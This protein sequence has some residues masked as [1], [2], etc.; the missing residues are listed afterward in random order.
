LA[1]VAGL[2]IVSIRPWREPAEGLVK[3][4][5][6]VSIFFLDA[7]MVPIIFWVPDT[8]TGARSAML[9]TNDALIPMDDWCGSTK[10]AICNRLERK[11]RVRDEADRQV[12]LISSSKL[13]PSF[14]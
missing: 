4:H 7:S 14:A 11:A 1:A 5:T 9:F 13:V 3:N 8:G 10:L 6:L 12:K 2:T